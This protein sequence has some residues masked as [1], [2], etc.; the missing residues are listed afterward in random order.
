[1]VVDKIVFRAS[2]REPNNK[3]VDY[4][5][6]LKENPYGAIIKYYNGTKWASIAATNTFNPLDY[7][8]K[9]QVNDLI[10]VA[11]NNIDANIASRLTILEDKVKQ[12]EENWKNLDTVLDEK[13][14]DFLKKTDM[15][16]IE[17]KW[18]ENDVE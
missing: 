5:I 16:P 18:I 15:A 9:K 10:D 3:E 1:M 12:L 6:D 14:K 8:N 2:Y 7:Y 11:I 13:L 17:E 4:W